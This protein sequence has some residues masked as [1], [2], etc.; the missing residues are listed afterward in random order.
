[1]HTGR[2]M[3]RVAFEQLPAQ[4]MQL[5]PHRQRAGQVVRAQ[6]ILFHADK[7]QLRTRRGGLSPQL[8]GGEKIEPGAKAGFT[9]GEAC[10]VLE[11]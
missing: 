11:L 10:P 8:P 6:G 7:M 3:G 5:R 1:M 4:V 2:E 9:N